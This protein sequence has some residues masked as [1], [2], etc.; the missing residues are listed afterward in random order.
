MRVTHKYP[1]FNP[2]HVSRQKVREC[3]QMHIF[4]YN[5]L[6]FHHFDFKLSDI[7]DFNYIFLKNITFKWFLTH[8]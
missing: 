2:F 5:F 4:A 3:E 8:N 7:I 6:G 1:R